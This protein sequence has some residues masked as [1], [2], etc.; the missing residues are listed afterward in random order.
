MKLKEI[1]DHLASFAPLAYQESYDNAGLIT[2]NHD[3]IISGILICLDSI[4][5]TIDEAIE[6]ECNLIISHHPIVFSG[7]KTL[8]GKTLIE[9]IIIKAIKNN[10][11]IYAAHTNLDNV[12]HGVNKKIADKLG[13]VNCKILLPKNK[14]LR[15]LITYCPTDQSEAVRQA[16]FLA[17]AGE[18]GNYNECSF[19]TEGFGTFRASPNAKPQIGEKGKQNREKEIKIEVIYAMHLESNLLKALFASHPYEEVA[20]DLIT[21]ENNYALVGSGMIAELEK[22]EEELFFLKRLKLIMQTPY[23]RHTRLLGKK[24]KKVALCGGSG[25]FLIPNAIASGADLFI[26][27]DMKYHQFFDA[28]NKLIIADIGHYESEQF[29]QELFYDILSKKFPTFA[30]HLSKINTNPIN[31][32]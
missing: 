30:L 5:E 25:S 11:A 3:M 12:I 17:G 9:R 13:L 1:T 21:L 24:I 27:A 31:Y 23:V 7:L 20:Y 26:T 16:L 19:N 22:E 10:I 6:K 2:G 28:Q 32:L 15:K 29:T 18:I 4:E 8:T 14:L